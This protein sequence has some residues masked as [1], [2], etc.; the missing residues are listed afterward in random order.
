MRVSIDSFDPGEIRTAVDAGAE[1]VLSV[2][3]SNLAV[4]RDL[5]GAKNP[6]RRDPD[7]GRGI[8]TLEPSITELERW[9]VSYLIDPVIEPI[10]FG[11]FTSLERFAEVRQRYPTPRSSWGSGTSPSSRQRTRLA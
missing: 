8:E 5:A 4:A 2:N 1:L 9:G 7:F 6:R 3:G 11:F 10:G